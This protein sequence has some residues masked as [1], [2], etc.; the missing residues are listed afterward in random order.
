MPPKSRS[1]FKDLFPY[2]TLLQRELATL[3]HPS[4]IRAE[5]VGMTVALDVSYSKDRAYAAAVVWKMKGEKVM[6]E[7][8][9]VFGVHFPYIPGYLYLREAPALLRVLSQVESDYDLILV[10]AHGRLHPR[11]AG[12]ATIVGVL[13]EKPTVGIAKS[14]LTGEIRGE[15]RVRPVYIRGE[16]EG[17]CMR[18][19]RTYYASPGNRMSIEEIDKWLKGR[20]YAYPREL[21]RA[22]ALSKH[23]RVTSEAGDPF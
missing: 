16:V 15:G 17:L 14:M 4:G 11:K 1:T 3:Y 19:G 8:T 2:A 23:L 22:D 6:E 5:E 20:G 10:D 21:V 7:Q 18:D 9:G 13:M 12:L